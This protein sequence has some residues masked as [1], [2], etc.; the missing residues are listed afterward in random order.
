MN[1][2]DA[3]ASD[4]APEQSPEPAWPTEQP[5]AQPA[6]PPR[7]QGT[8]N[9]LGLPKRV[10]KAGLFPSTGAPAAGPANGASHR[11]PNRTRGFLASYQSGIRQ[12]HTGAAA[13]SE[14]EKGQESP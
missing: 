13:S 5:V 10:P 11:D 7:P 8:Q 9:G 4:P 1:P 14:N 2:S 12:D 3:T 6:P